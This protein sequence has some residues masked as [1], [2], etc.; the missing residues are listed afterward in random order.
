MNTPL[1]RLEIA[2]LIILPLG[3]SPLFSYVSHDVVT[4]GAYVAI[5]FGK[6]DLTGVVYSCD[7]LPGKAPSW[8]KPITEVIREDFL[9]QEQCS[10]ARRISEEYFTPLGKTLKHFLP[11]VV[12]VRKNKTASP[13]QKHIAL[14]PKK[15]ESP[16]LALFGKYPE[17]IPLYLDASALPEPKHFFALLSKKMKSEGLQTLL[18]VPEITLIPG[19]AA[20]FLKHFEKESIAILHSQLSD[21]AYFQAWERIRSGQATVIIATRQGLFAPFRNL[22]L[23]IVTEEQDESYKQWDMSPR[24]DGRRVANMLATL[25]GAKILFTSNT[26]SIESRYA[27]KTKEYLPIAPPSPTPALGDKLTI[28]NLKLERFK[29]NYSP[30]SEALV[31]DLRHTLSS[32]H[33]ALLYINRQG[34]SLFSVCENCKSIFRCPESD[35][36]LVGTKEGFFRCLACNYKTGLFP[37]CPECGHLSFRSVGFGT[38]RIEKEIYRVL[39][40]ARIFRADGSTMRK[41]GAAAELYEKGTTGHIDILIGTQMILKDPP[42]PKLSLIAMIDADSL[43]LFPDFKADER[44]FQHIER[45]VK[46][47]AGGRVIIQT[48]HPESTFFQRVTGLDSLAISEQILAERNVLLYPPFARLVLITYQG[49]DIQDTEKSTKHAFESLQKM[50][51][52]KKGFKVSPPQ[53]PEFLKRRNLFE[54]SLLIRIPSTTDMPRDLIRFLNQESK[55]CRVDVDPISFK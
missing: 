48:F 9:T 1:Y 19:L 24:Y 10:L 34:M 12:K 23:I 20:T 29:K 53:T 38:E 31:Q 40:G 42:L 41:P 52:G 16:A 30:L 35:H 50:L 14:K 54:S 27:I 47:V 8:M 15:D 2:P 28:V 46:Q 25:H 26:P 7:S 45:A 33:Q 3:R 36:P 51:P 6:R 17:G 18:L 4:P 5:P 21:G 43:L 55:R 37:S 13:E 44:L 49:K 22:G 11:K 32:G 39:P